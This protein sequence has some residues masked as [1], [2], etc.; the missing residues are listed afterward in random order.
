MSPLSFAEVRNSFI[1]HYETLEF[2]HL[3]RA[4]MLHPSI[5]MSFVMSAG[6]V[7]IESALESDQLASGDRFLLVQDCFRHFDKRRVTKEPHHLSLFEMSGAFEF[8]EFNHS[9][10]IEKLWTFIVKELK[11]D[12]ERIWAS[13]FEGGKIGGSKVGQDTESYEAWRKAGAK[14]EQIVALPKEENFWMQGGMTSG[15]NREGGR[16]CGS[17]AELFFDKGKSYS[18]SKNCMPS[19]R[20][21]RFVE[22]ANVLFVQYDFLEQEDTLRS[23]ELPFA[24]T[25]IGNERLAMVTQDKQEVFDID[26]YRKLRAYLQKVVGA[27][28]V[29]G[30]EVLS[31]MN[32]VIDHLRALSVLVADAA[33]PPGRGGRAHIIKG[34]IRGVLSRLMVLGVPPEKLL[35]TT[36]AK[37]ERE[38]LK[39]DELTPQNRKKVIEYFAMDERRFNKTVKAGQKYIL[40]KLKQQR[41][42]GLTD[43]H[44]EFIE[45]R[46]GV[47]EILINKIVQ[48]EGLYL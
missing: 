26:S 29:K 24:E 37:I 41:E 23:I 10:V 22:F 5:P 46:L 45:K 48:E 1:R 2:R 36:L 34:L 44:V 7:Q 38:F 16:K 6:L 17:N 27:S 14:K 39:P 3:P 42:S 47:P 43:E 31:D 12:P 11:V 21:G 35:E 40:N 9:K 32:L 4:S 18:C 25:V 19:C 13:Y 30:G 28:E 15:N 8:G 33:P 20:C